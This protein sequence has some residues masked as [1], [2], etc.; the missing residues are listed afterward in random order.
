MKKALVFISNN[1][2]MALDEAVEKCQNGYEIYFVLCDSS[3]RAC[4]VC[5]VCDKATCVLCTHAMKGLIRLLL[6]SNKLYHMEMM[7]NLINDDIKKQ[8]EE[9]VFSY[10]D[11][12]SLKDITYHDV[13]IG[14]GAFSTFVTYTRNVMPT[15]NDALKD[16]LDTLM[17]SQ[18]RE[19]L[20]LEKYV[21][22]IKPD[23]MVFH[24]GRFANLKPLLNIAK[25][26]K[27]EYVVTEQWNFP[28]GII[29]RNFFHNDIPHSFRA[30]EKKFEIAWKNV[31]AEGA[32]I[33][34]AFFE[35][36]RYGKYAGDKIYTENQQTGLLPDNFN[37]QKRNI[38]IFNSSEDEFFAISKEWDES[39]L[40]PNQYIA[41]KTI[42]EHYKDDDTI[43]F[44]LRIHPNLKNVPWKSHM[45]LYDLKYT[46][47][48]IIPP[49]SPISSY[50]LMDKSEKVIV[51]N[52]TMGIESAYWGKPVI[53]LNKC[54]YSQLHQV[55]EPKTEK[56]IY[57]MIDKQ[58]LLPLRDETSCY[59]VA[60][61]CMGYAA[62]DYRHYKVNSY[63]LKHSIEVINILKL[64]GSPV[65]YA[66]ACRVLNKL[67]TI[68]G[69][70]RR[71]KDL[72]EKTA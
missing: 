56:E 51:F 26:R 28:N 50:A 13:E 67:S 2:Y 34:K 42:F 25:N 44:Y 15:F 52:S 48:T 62:D 23:L 55:Y 65:L 64:W 14:Y 6:K 20:A 66:Y 16:Y 71:F 47:V 22:S 11:V 45:L 4:N 27:I 63:R 60:C 12:K 9:V 1:D 7:S 72:A 35:N 8:A 61:Y 43:H 33:G 30:F 54:S 40:F 70:G 5:R 19:T 69:S 46:N 3:I 21:D 58:A 32:N 41:L 18:V 39:V 59:K 29:K 17:R 49:S 36:R 57:E 10:S 38:S 31:G 53:A 24:N 37:T 68:I